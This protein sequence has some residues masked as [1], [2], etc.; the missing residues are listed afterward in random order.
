MFHNKESV[1]SVANF[2]QRFLKIILVSPEEQ[3]ILNKACHMN[4]RQDM[5]VGWTFDT[6][7]PFERLKK[8]NIEFDLYP[9]NA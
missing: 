9:T 1:E 2:I 8:A 4:L 5:P 6:G 7:D 3:A